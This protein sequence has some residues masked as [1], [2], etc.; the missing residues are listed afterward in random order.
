M[1]HCSER[2]CVAQKD[3]W[4]SDRHRAMGS[5]LVF[6]WICRWIC[7]RPLNEV[8]SGQISLLLYIYG[9]GYTHVDISELYIGGYTCMQYLDDR[10]NYFGQEMLHPLCGF[11]CRSCKRQTN[12]QQKP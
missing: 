6:R 4:T 2:V 11:S 8:P 3:I 9:G 7:K 10:Y 1:F 12:K 5:V